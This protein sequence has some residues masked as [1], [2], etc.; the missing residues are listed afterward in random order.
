MGSQISTRGDV[1]S[2]GILLLEMFTRKRP[3]DEIF[4]DGTGLHKLV[5]M[6]FPDRV[7]DVVDPCILSQAGDTKSTGIS[8]DEKQERNVQQEYCLASALRI[9]LSCSNEDPRE[10][11]EMRTVTKEL[12][13]IRDLLLDSRISE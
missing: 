1:F 12:L 8:L 7:M 5:E 3:T 2:Y 10:R 13:A 11:M 6:A 9:G 4:K